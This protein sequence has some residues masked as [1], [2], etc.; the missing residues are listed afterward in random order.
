[1]T[2]LPPKRPH[3]LKLPLTMPKQSNTWIFR[4]QTYSNHH[5]KQVMECKPVSS[6]P[7]WF[8]L[9]ILP[10]GSCPKFLPDFCGAKHM[11]F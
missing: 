7:P 3:S 8:L 9:Q 2:T 11:E 6:V 10:G 4:D 5:T 1:L